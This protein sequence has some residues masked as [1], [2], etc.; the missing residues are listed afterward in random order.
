MALEIPSG[1]LRLGGR[2]PSLRIKAS[3]FN[4]ATSVTSGTL[5][6]WWK[7]DAGALD[8]SDA[9]ITA[10]GTAVKTWQDQSGN[11]RHVTQGTAGA[12][13]L[14]KTAIQ[15]GKPVIRFDGTDDQ[16]Q[17]ASTGIMTALPLTILVAAASAT[18]ATVRRV[19]TNGRYGFACGAAS[20]KLRFTIFGVADK[21]S[22]A[23]IWV[24]NT[25]EQV[26]L[27]FDSSRVVTIWRN[28]VNT[29]TLAAAASDSG[30]AVG[31]L[32]IGSAGGSEFW[33]LDIGEILVY[34]GTLSSTDRAAAEAYLKARWGTP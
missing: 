6:G 15:N 2:G 25:F 34:S 5:K 17:I 29:D 11:T 33:N 3:G 22:A 1:P 21:D 19:I 9:A 26:S 32:S 13:P 20:Q 7:A 27:T 31:T 18:T 23:A 4:P 24:A 12:R 30:N 8:A 14:Y 28:G 16:L 10:D